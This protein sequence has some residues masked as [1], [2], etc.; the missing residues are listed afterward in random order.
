[1]IDTAFA[2]AAEQ[3]SGQP[4]LMEMLLMPA[5]FLF[6]F[7]FLLLRP[8][9]KK[10]KEHKELL[11]NL[12]VGDEIITSGGIIGKVKSMADGFLTIDSGTS[13]LKVV[14]EH[15]SALTAIQKASAPEKVAPQ[16]AK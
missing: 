8:Q 6:I 10:A 14:K 4:S 1:M 5:A 3:A 15:V 9:A 13:T 2:Q 7:Y 11:T 16:K 12:K